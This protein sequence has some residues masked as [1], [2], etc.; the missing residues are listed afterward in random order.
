MNAAD[1][2][3]HVAILREV[4]ELLAELDGLETIRVLPLWLRATRLLEIA[5]S[6]KR[7]RQ[8]PQHL[9]RVLTG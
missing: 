9:P 7:A 2:N 8:A 3:G 4:E 5:Q 1:P 6:L